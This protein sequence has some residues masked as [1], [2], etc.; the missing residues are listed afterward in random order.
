MTDRATRL[1]QT[2][3]Q[4]LN[5]YKTFLRFPSISADPA[6]RA[7]LNACADWI[8]TRLRSMGFTVKKWPTPNRCPVIFAEHLQAGT[9]KPTILLY[10][11]YDV[12]P[13]DPLEEWHS[14]PFEPTVRDDVVYARGAQDNKGQC[15]YVLLGL[16]LLL[17]ETGN[18]PL[19]IKLCIE[20]EEEIGSPGLAQLLN[21]KR[22]NVKAD[23]V[24]IVD[25]GLPDAQT[26]TLTLGT[27]GI[28][29]MDVEVRSA[30]RDLHSG[31]HGGLAPNAL[32]IMIHL[33]DSLHE[34]SGRIAVPGF[35]DSMIDTSPEEMQK[36]A[37]TFDVD[38]YVAT[39]GAHP[40]GGERKLSP[41]IRSWLQPTLEING[42][43]GGYTGAGFKTIIPA[44][45][46]A[47]LSCRLVPGQDPAQIG[48]L[49][50]NYLHKQTPP[51]VHM[52]VDIHKGQGRAVRISSDAKIVR[53]FSASFEEIFGKPCQFILEGASIPIVPAL[54]VASGGEPVMLGLGLTTDLIHAP[55]EHFSLD[56]IEK[57]ALIIARA[58]E[59]LTLH[60]AIDTNLLRKVDL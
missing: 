59:H 35:Y 40:I 54:M 48:Q 6:Y 31:T 37:T 9:D 15:F 33:L 43:S 46:H 23:Y 36:L 12:Q 2:R 19:N 44:K 3:D 38:H 22:E 39:H 42:L 55:N 52:T 26:P 47:K 45:A 34:P 27:R 30:S 53:A 21:E 1:K 56:R 49:V 60:K 11:H 20:G 17:E 58:L 41:I 13:V 8:V 7:D 51:E 16:A 25:L 50:A 57:G 5:D 29:T 14:P 24:A 28:I 18:F 4:W 10:N 32:Q